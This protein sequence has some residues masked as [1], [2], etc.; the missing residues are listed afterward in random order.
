MTT[1]AIC[2]QKSLCLPCGPQPLHHHLLPCKRLFWRERAVLGIK[3]RT[4][5]LNHK[6]M[7]LLSPPP[8]ELGLQA[9]VTS[10]SLRRLFAAPSLAKPLQCLLSSSIREEDPLAKLRGPR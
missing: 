3:S 10:S 5:L 4:F 1:A 7:I 8:R 9:Y 6:F 2:M